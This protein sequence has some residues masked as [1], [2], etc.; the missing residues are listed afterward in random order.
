[1]SYY[2]SDYLYHHGILGQRWGKR[3]GPPYPLSPSSH[4][5]AEKRASEQLSSEEYK[6][7][8]TT[9]RKKWSTKKKIAVGAAV[10]AAAL[11]AI[12]GMYVY[13]SSKMPIHIET[14]RFG[15]K[16]DIS[17]LST[18]EITLKAGTKLHRVSSKSFEDY[19]KDGKSIYTSYKKKDIH[20]YKNQMPKYIAQWVKQ[21]LVDGDG[22]KAYEHVMITKHDLKIPSQKTVAEI[23]MKTFGQD[24]ID[25]G[26]YK[27]FMEKMVDRDHPDV[28]KF[29]SAI[30]RSGYNAIVDEHDTNWADSPLILLNPKDDIASA[31]SHR[32]SA[33]EKVINV[34]TY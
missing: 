19:A 15:T 28:K 3:N 10:T 18:E 26:R 7:T 4:S 12:G 21:G 9:Q 20:L 13:K 5:Y 33:V 6:S 27:Q 22:K 1:M 24:H 23:Y 30:R 34:L 2:K 31:K 8:K 16:V 25:D 32:I 29:V 17:K 14:L 11:V